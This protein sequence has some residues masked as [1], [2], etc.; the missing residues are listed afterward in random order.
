MIMEDLVIK[1]STISPFVFFDIKTCLFEI[2]GTCRPEH[3]SDFFMPIFNWLNKLEELVLQN[4]QLNPV[5]L[6]ISLEYINSVSIKILYDVLKVFE[7][8]NNI[9]N[10]ISIIWHY[11]RGDTD[12]K[13]SGEEYQTIINTPFKICI[14]K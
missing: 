10:N 14:E 9:T 1:K 12:M 4:Y 2:R 11:K 6:N 13:E 3:A 5:Q 8:I 7:R